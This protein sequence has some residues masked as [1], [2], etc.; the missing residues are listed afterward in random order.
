MTKLGAFAVTVVAAGTAAA[1]ATAAAPVARAARAGATRT[2]VVLYAR[3]ASLAGAHRAIHRAGGRILRENR[4]IGLAT[5]AA[6][7]RGFV[8]RATAAAAIQGAAANRPI[9]H[10]SGLPPSRRIES[11]RGAASTRSVTTAAGDAPPAAEPLSANQWDMRM[12]HA[13]PDGSY[14]VQTGSDAVRVGIIDTGVDGSHP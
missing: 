11:E 12:M 5:V 13:T 14:A 2:Y 6:R 7:S 8:R 1:P 9:G 3:G 10:L 4:R